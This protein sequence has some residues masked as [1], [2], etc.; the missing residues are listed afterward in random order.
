MKPH[1]GV[2]KDG[3]N[4]WLYNP[5]DSISYNADST[6]VRHPLV[7][8]LHGA[9]LCGDNIDRV[10]TYGTIDAIEKGRKLDAYVVAPQNPGGAWIPKRI[11]NVV[12]WVRQ[13]HQ[14]DSNR[15]YAIGMSL[16]GYGTIDLAATY[17]DKIAAAMALCGGGSVKD[18]SGL[19]YVPLW[20]IHG[21]ADRAVTIRQSDRVVEAMKQTDKNTPRLKY[22]RIPGMNHGQPARF[23][24][25]ADSYEWLLNHSLEDEN[26]PVAETFEP[27]NG[28]LSKAYDGLSFKNGK[29][30]K[31]RQSKARRRRK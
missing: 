9:S 1:T 12:E 21:T 24:Y 28:I 15:I 18:L 16:G 22:N 17:P 6:V 26:R 14:V 2:V 23:L 29:A 13:H 10:R 3:Y 4:F 8:F 5:Y 27:G 31:R 11:M 30:K 25:L 7:I 19:N 20:I